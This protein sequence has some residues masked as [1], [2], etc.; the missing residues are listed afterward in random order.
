MKKLTS[1]LLLLF[2]IIVAK[3][4]NFIIKAE[5][6]GFKDHS[7]FYLKENPTNNEKIDSAELINGKLILKGKIAG[8]KLLW[9][10]SYNNDV[11]SYTSFL[12]G[13]DQVSI[14]ANAKD[15]PW[16][17]K[18]A[19]SKSQDIAAILGKKINPLWIERDSLMRILMPLALGKQSDSI[20]LIMQPLSLKINKLDSIR[21]SLTDQFIAKYYNSH[22]GLKELYNRKKKYKKEELVAL[23][24]KVSSEYKSGFFGKMISNY[25]KIGDILKKGDNFYDFEAK[26]IKGLKYKLSNYKGKYILLDFTETYCTGCILAAEDLKAVATKYAHK[27]QIISFYA[28][29]DKQTM[30]KGIDRDHPTWLSLWDGKGSRSEILLKYGVNAY[31][32]FVLIEPSGK[33]VSHFSGSSKSNNGKGNVESEVERILNLPK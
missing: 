25:I 23:L 19:G 31:P 20:K 30:Q 27:V 14:K 2:I 21:E 33:I 28:E 6:T 3:A 7:I 22:A 1:S 17:V 5:L 18:V 32:T 26:D 9:L 10:T 4:Q 8:V 29:T 13:A 15:F 11:L 12:M 16:N 24:A